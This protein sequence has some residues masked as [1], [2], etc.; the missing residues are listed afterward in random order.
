MEKLNLAFYTDTYEPA[1]DGVVSSIVN[2]KKELESRGH[3]VYIFTSTKFLS[4]TPKRKNIFLY[5]GVGFK[6]YPQY[7]M[8][9]FPY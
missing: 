1:I 2:F 7:S 9:F 5:P 3:S 4:K 8:A 6:P